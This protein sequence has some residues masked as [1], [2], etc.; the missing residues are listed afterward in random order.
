[1]GHITNYNSGTEWLLD[2][3][4]DM[5]EVTGLLSILKTLWNYFYK[6]LILLT[7]REVKSLARENLPE[8]KSYLGLSDF[9]LRI[10]YT[11]TPL[12]RAQCHL[13][14]LSTL[15]SS[16]ITFHTVL[17]LKHDFHFHLCHTDFTSS[18]VLPNEWLIISEQSALTEPSITMVWDTSNYLQHWYRTFS[19]WRNRRE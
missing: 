17:Q 4:F 3:R 8:H 18:K 12:I 14:H 19:P 13:Y 5:K 15:N 1:M 10:P 9:R 6:L 7:L 2:V 11:T 16:D